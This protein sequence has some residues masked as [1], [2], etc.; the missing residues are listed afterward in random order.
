MDERESVTPEARFGAQLRAL[1]EREGL[2]IRQ[3]AAALHRAHSGI[4]DYEQGRRL[5]LVDVVEQ[6]E[7][8]FGLARGTLGALREQ[9][10]AQRAEDPLDGTCPDDLGIVACP[11]KGLH[12][13]QYEDAGLFF[14]REAQVDGVCERLERTRFVAVVGASGSGKSSF[15]RAGLIAGVR[16]R[17]DDR[18][19]PVVLLTPGEH[20][21]QR[22][23]GAFATAIGV[24]MSEEDLRGDRDRLRRE[25]RAV[26]APR[27]LVVV[28]QF[29]ELFMRCDDKR[30]RTCFVDS[31]IAAWR[32]PASP[33]SLVVA[34]RADFYGRIAEHPELAAAVVGHQELIGALTTADLRRAIELPAAAC[35]LVV[36][37][38]LAETIIEDLAGEPGALPLLS[39]AL[40]ETWKRRRRLTLTVSGYL[41]AGGVRGAIAQTA[42][43]T[44]QRLPEADQRIARSIFLRLTDVDERTQPTRRRI[45]HDE[46][47]ATSQT[48]GG[49]ER[50]LGT[51]ARA[52][53]ITIDERSVEMAHESLIRHWP[54]L[55]GWIDADRAGLLVHRRLTEAAGEWDAHERDPGALYRGTRL[56]VAEEWASDHMDDLSVLER[57]FLRS[58]AELERDEQAAA[59]R[60]TRRLRVLAAGL[61][62]LTAIVALVAASALHQ[63]GEARRQAA[64]ATSLALASSSLP[65]LDTRPD[66][67]LLLGLE[68]Y[69]A[70]PLPEARGAVVTALRLARGPASEGI[71]R[72]HANAVRKVAFGPGGR[73]LA[74]MG[75][76][77]TV[78]LWDVRAHRQVGAPLTGKGYVSDVAFGPPG[79]VLAATIDRGR[80]RL[81]DVRTG[82]PF[83]GPPASSVR[84]IEF[85]NMAFSRDGR[86]LAVIVD[87]DTIRLW[88]VDA[89]TFVGTPMS[90]REPAADI[91][92]SRDGR[93]LASPGVFAIELWNTR[94]STR[95]GRALRSVA[96]P[97]TALAFSPDGRTLASAGGLDGTIR[98]W[99]VATSAPRGQP[100]RGHTDRVTSLAFS[101]DGRTLASASADKSIRL[102]DARTR[103]QRG[104]PLTGH[105]GV[106]EDVAFS[107]DGRRLASAGADTTIR[108]WDVRA[109]LRSADRLKGHAAVLSL[110]F[111]PDGRT[112]ASA[113][114]DGAARLW[115]VRR[116]R[117]RTALRGHTRS[118]NAVGFSRD[119]R[120]LASAGADSTI[121]LWNADTERQL[122]APLT[123]PRRTI[124]APP[125]RMNIVSTYDSVAFS[126]D[127]RTVLSSGR[128]SDGTLLWDV[129]T[130]GRT[131]LRRN[132]VAAAL[133]PDG[134]T[135]ASVGVDSRI[136]LWDARNRKPRGASLAGHTEP[137]TTIAFSPDGRTLMSGS[138]DKTLR[139]WDV[140]SHKQ[141]GAPL[142]GHTASVSSVAFSADG[143]TLATGSADRTV[144]LWDAR[145]HKQLGRPLPGR[146]NSP[147]AFSPDGRTLASISG[148][149]TIRLWTRLLWRSLAELRSEVCDLVGGGLTRAE[150][151]QHAPGIP[152]RNGCA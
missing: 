7:D 98:L 109:A 61:A 12:A 32:D 1:R 13:F 10:R 60:K 41:E 84:R 114:L 71:L 103:T 9:A 50:V 57:A 74:S 137:V 136:R 26:A 113:G 21:V 115:D 107:P 59:K 65:L 140:R 22:L 31:L 58:S 134:R 62:A 80:L 127:G 43:H 128:G 35:G 11:Y 91:A 96:G 15:V 53:L 27:V 82:K 97:R 19:A 102:W 48:A 130:G 17:H 67:A 121:R 33:V 88:D 79:R 69:S 151:A 138:F 131:L 147:V 28:D 46:L 125:R 126:G 93:T 42:E 145:T 105:A 104:E 132:D 56:A 20:P 55:G 129:R 139:V 144:R 118:I 70:S 122:G 39:H 49:T 148:T 101:P 30:E 24:D 87:L 117:L 76:D 85:T 8:H 68:A 141:L 90:G 66:V 44:L 150:W 6:Y 110:A 52:R 143:R 116:Q 106:V 37:H 146:L 3:L 18:D 73:T 152:Y 111:S 108:L 5:P 142:T 120:M 123:G 119:G 149:G 78:R 83:S 81:W 14:G 133:A 47:A 94:T 40:L 99:D 2:S 45:E 34:V 29:E 75:A 124:S 72:G 77:N 89:R 54:R 36:Q 64:R 23:A 100:L 95:H 16:A 92:F 86:R 25:I 51:L 38:G 4:V 135:I 63:R 112:L